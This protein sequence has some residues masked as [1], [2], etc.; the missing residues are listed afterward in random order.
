M[1][2][3]RKP[4]V[5]ER[6]R[7]NN[8]KLVI[9]QITIKAPVRKTSDVAAWRTALQSG[10]MGRPKLL[11]DLYEDLLIDGVLSDAIDKRIKAVT[12]SELTFQDADG[13][14][15]PDLTDLLDSPAWEDL[16]EGIMQSRFWGRAGIEF[17]FANGFDAKLI[18]PKHIKLENLQILLN[19]YDD[20]GVS[21]E[22]DDHLL[23][24]GKKR[25]FGLML[26][27]A[28]FAIWKRGGFGDY[29]QWLEIFG[30][31]Q[32]VGKY[33]SYDPESRKLLEEAM[34]KAGSAPWI[35]IP[36][37]SEVETTN[38]SGTGSSGKSY[39]EFR[40]ACNEEMLITILGQTMTTVQG[41]KGARS[42]G[43]VHKEVEEGKNRADMRFVQRVLNHFVLPLLEKRGF[44]VTGGKFIFPKAAEA[45]TVDEIVSLSGLIDIPVMYLHNKY[46]IPAAKD[47]EEIV[48]R[49]QPAAPVNV[50]PAKEPGKLPD[51]VK[52]VKADGTEKPVKPE[53]PGKPIK[54]ADH[55]FFKQFF[56]FF[57]TAPAVMT[58][59]STGDH[60]TLSD[61]SLSD[62]IIK[63]VTDNRGI[64]HPELF[65][66]IS[67]DLI[68]ALDYR[69][70]KLADI[71]FVYNY[72]ND[73]FR[74]AQ[75]LNLFHFSAAK[76]LAELQRLNELFRQ[77]KSS[78]EFY[79]LASAEMEVFNKTWQKTEWETAA[80]IAA[81]TENYNRLSGKTKLFPYWEYC[82][83]GDDKV[84]P[85][86]QLLNGIVL[87]ADDP[88]WKKI[89]PPNGWKCRCYIVP[90]LLS[91]VKDID[92][93]VQRAIVD[94]YFETP[95]WASATAQGFGVNRAML[96]ELFNE[97]QMY[98]EK[99]KGQAGT[100]L[101]DI[102]FETYG[103][104][105]AVEMSAIADKLFEAYLG[106]TA[107][108][109]K[110][111]IIEEGK[112][113]FKDFKGRSVLF[114]ESVL[115]KGSAGIKSE[116]IKMLTGVG[117]ALKAP[118][119]VWI[120]NADGKLFDQYV[121]LKYYTDQTLAVIAEIK[122]GISYQVKTWLKADETVLTKKYRKGL[123]IK[124]PSV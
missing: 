59:A 94:A 28:P 71:G 124:K 45:L 111:M 50:D 100:L 60:L 12:N 14:E 118:D 73:A 98:I 43:E 88:R 34:E 51:P 70:A 97:N 69:P 35:V 19:E 5:T 119:E 25:D 8:S 52:P 57:V 40:K 85:E 39:D 63:H 67:S 116:R 27:T 1:A 33:S 109:L 42:L 78:G 123:L 53:K 65:H 117:E 115:L 30:M 82:T 113:F 108:F 84:R 31:P 24:L 4:L 61:S 37:E 101:K 76:N 29:A 110:Q 87:P 15:V 55:G 36:K 41:D 26:K 121:F 103:L 90:R 21:Y 80:L 95:E 7:S 2:T 23:I 105:P 16:L 81:S 122:E 9:N 89:W 46:S 79:K 91:E 10:D 13:S 20:S 62:R 64:F 68:T 92:L 11:F 102:N 99:F 120:N 77:S 112:L 107:D 3:K 106:T 47:G 72:Q 96:P 83:V 86:H 48:K 74:T 38:T 104:K 66:F 58:G 114:D 44:P 22:G 54:N 32:R 75:E 49:A 56:D 6:A 17:D 93:E 18:P